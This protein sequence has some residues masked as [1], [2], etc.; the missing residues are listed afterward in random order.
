MSSL[1]KTN[2]AIQRGHVKRMAR[3]LDIL[4]CAK[5]HLSL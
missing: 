4:D 5:K 3:F 2:P 1:G